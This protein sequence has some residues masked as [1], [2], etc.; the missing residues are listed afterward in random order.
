MMLT[1]DMLNP[2]NNVVVCYSNIVEC[3]QSLDC[4]SGNGIDL[5]DIYLSNSMTRKGPTFEGFMTALL[6]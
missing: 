6:V 2:T 1:S 3:K 4:L 5:S